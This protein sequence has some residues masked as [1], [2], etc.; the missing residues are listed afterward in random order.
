MPCWELIAFCPHAHLLQ[1]Q[2][3][4]VGVIAVGL[5]NVAAARKFADLLQFPLDLLY[6]GEGSGAFYS[7]V[8][9]L[10]IENSGEACYT[11]AA[12]PAGSAVCPEGLA[13]LWIAI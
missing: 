7:L 11:F 3:A 8:I 5:G 4:G 10:L 2:G 12:V 1:L 9:V 13:L 6:A